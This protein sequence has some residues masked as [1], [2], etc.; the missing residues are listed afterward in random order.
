MLRG[1]RPG[2]EDGW[3][4]ILWCKESPENDYW[5]ISIAQRGT[6]RWMCPTSNDERIDHD[7]GV[8]YTMRFLQNPRP[9]REEGC[10]LS[11]VT[12]GMYRSE[13]IVE[14]QSPV[15]QNGEVGERVPGFDLSCLALT[16]ATPGQ[17]EE[18]RRKGI[19]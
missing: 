4:A 18:E 19:Q 8:I 7:G 3:E 11:P 2:L 10:S 9:T 1:V 16:D 13:R 15:C 14:G 5:G 6:R 12:K 17:N